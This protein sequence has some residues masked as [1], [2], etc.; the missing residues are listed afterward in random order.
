VV[1]ESNAAVKAVCRCQ[2]RPETSEPDALVTV[3][4]I[5]VW[6]IGQ[7][8]T[9]IGDAG[10]EHESVIVIA[11][12]SG[13]IVNDVV[14]ANGP[15][16]SDRLVRRKDGLL[17]TEPRWMIQIIIVPVRHDIAGCGFSAYGPFQAQ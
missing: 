7:N 11:V 13:V 15:I 9:V 14:E 5:R 16:A 8:G 4:Q 12:G 3:G 10:A 1:V 2:E 17:F 6:M